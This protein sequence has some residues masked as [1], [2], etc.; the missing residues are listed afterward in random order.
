MTLTVQIFGIHDEPKGRVAALKTVFLATL[1]RELGG[2]CAI[3]TNGVDNTSRAYA[4][5][6]DK[7]TN[8]L[9]SKE[10]ITIEEWRRI[11]TLVLTR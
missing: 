3:T 11:F 4:K 10:L 1:T 8:E 5:A 7:A 6:K 9:L 2:E